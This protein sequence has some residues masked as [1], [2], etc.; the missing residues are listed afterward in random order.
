MRRN[1][2]GRPTRPGYKPKKRLDVGVFFKHIGL[3]LLIIIVLV[4]GFFVASNL[5]GGDQNTPEPV[6]QAT[7][8]PEPTAEPTPEATPEP[9]PTPWVVNK[10]AEHGAQF[11]DIYNGFEGEKVAYLTF[12]DGPT[13]NVTPK[14]LEILREKDVKAT[15][16]VLGKMLT[17]YPELAQ[18]AVSEGHVLAN[19]S[20]SHDYKQIYGST[21][22]FLDEIKKAENII[23]NTVGEEGYT[24]V[25]R[26]PGGSHNRD[27]SFKNALL[28]ENYVYVDWNV[29]SGDAE[30]HNISPEKQLAKVKT[31]AKGLNH[32]VVLMHDAATKKTTAEA[33]PQIIDYLRGEGYEFRTLKR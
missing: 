13:S 22:S 23:L 14:I 27:E 28:T 9:T 33:L 20:Y 8:P 3:P 25:F 26:F 18:Q 30:G 16:F 24:R 7:Q 12:D 17:A 21:E 32:I 15:F 19:H 29:I 31:T 10:T 4:G 5:T 2:H 11:V 1:Y 6:V